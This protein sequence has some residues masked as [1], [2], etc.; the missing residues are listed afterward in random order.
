MAWCAGY[1]NVHVGDTTTLSSI[2]QT[3]AGTIIWQSGRTNLLDRGYIL[4]NCNENANSV[5]FSLKRWGASI[6]FSINNGTG[7]NADAW[8]QDGDTDAT[9]APH[10][11]AVS[12]AGGVCNF[13][14]DG[15]RL[16]GIPVND[17]GNKKYSTS[18]TSWGA[19]SFGTYSSNPNVQCPT[20]LSDI[21]IFTNA[22]DDAEIYT[23]MARLKLNDTNAISSNMNSSVIG[24]STGNPITNPPSAGVIQLQWNWSYPPGAFISNQTFVVRHSTN[25]AL[26]LMQW[27]VFT[28]I[29]AGANLSLLVTTQPGQHY[30][31]LTALD[32]SNGSN[33]PDGSVSQPLL[34]GAISMQND[35]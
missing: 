2:W 29:T 21:L 16:N 22:L 9:G 33:S 15:K 17:K 8:I 24:N 25:L 10:I 7:T 30:F 19:L 20:F 14:E 18:A 31:A 34:R 6:R 23:R 13:F 4:D 5:G 32:L 12:F 26:P 35:H 3:G 27:P 11:F 28:N 1:T